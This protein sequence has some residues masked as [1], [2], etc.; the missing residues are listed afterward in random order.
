VQNLKP[1]TVTLYRDPHY[2]P[3]NDRIDFPG[4][5][6]LHLEVG[7][8]SKGAMP[9]NLTVAGKCLFTKAC[10]KEFAIMMRTN[11]ESKLQRIP[12][13]GKLDWY[14][15][16]FQVLCSQRV[17]PPKTPHNIA[18]AHFS[19]RPDCRCVQLCPVCGNMA[20]PDDGTVFWL[21]Y[22]PLL[23]IS[24]QANIG[25]RTVQRLTCPPCMESL[26]EGIVRIE[27]N[28]EAKSMMQV[29][30]EDLPAISFLDGHDN[31]IVG[32]K[33]CLRSDLTAYHLYL[34]WDNS[35]A[36]EANEN[37]KKELLQGA[38][39]GGNKWQPGEN[40]GQDFMVMN[41]EQFKSKKKL[42]GSSS[43]A[44]KGGKRSVKDLTSK[45][46]EEASCFSCSIEL[47]EDDC[48][49]CSRC[50]VATYCSRDCQKAHWRA[51]KLECSPPS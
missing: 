37:V 11:E 8:N 4:A 18:S 38:V 47:S 40:G 32:G 9:E 7:G 1:Q 5:V 6:V 21:L 28:G 42:E 39:G 26:L 29:L 49:C 46:K 44:S 48:M 25:M 17:H 22:Y 31:P 33:G 45:A 51:H 36:W 35:G 19:F 34:L 12:P 13:N 16:H 3:K 15:S 41:L 2:H 23:Q 24:A 50:K 20:E 30:D 10:Q 43:A 27:E 14:G